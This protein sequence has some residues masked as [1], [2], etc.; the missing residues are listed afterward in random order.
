ML[1]YVSLSASIQISLPQ[2]CLPLWCSSSPSLHHN[3][4]GNVL[5]QQSHSP[6][7]LQEEASPTKAAKTVSMQELTQNQVQIKLRES[8]NFRKK[9]KAQLKELDNIKWKI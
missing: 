7:H 3:S 4:L 8:K 2:V 9:I 5:S 1:I 6:L